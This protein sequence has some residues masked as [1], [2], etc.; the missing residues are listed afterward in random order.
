MKSIRSTRSLFAFLGAA[1]V[2]SAGS[3]A[4]ANYLFQPGPGYLAPNLPLNKDDYSAW[5]V[6]YTPYGSP[7]YPDIS[8]PFGTYQLASTAGVTPPANSSPVNP[9]A[10]WDPRNPTITQVGTSTAFII[11]PGTQGNIYSFSNPL[12]YQV[13]DATSYSD[14]L[15]L[16]QMQTEGTPVNFSSI[17]LQYTNSS[18]Q[19]VSLSPGQ[20]VTEYQ[21]ASVSGQGFSVTNRTALEWNL[22]GLNVSSFHIV[23]SSSAP[24]M[25]LQQVNMDTS[26]LYVSTVPQSRTWSANGNGVWS[27]GSNWAQGTSSIENANVLFN[28]SGAANVTL[29]ANHTVGLMTFGSAGNITLSSPGGFTL[30]ANTGIATTASATGTYTINNKYAFGDYN[31]FNIAS[32]KVQLNGVVSGNNGFFKQGEGTLELNGNNTFTG[33]VGMEGGT[34]RM[35][36]TNVY[37]GGTSIVWGKLVVAGNALNGT[38][39]AL[40]NDSSTISLGADSSLYSFQ[41]V[42]DPG[43]IVIDGDYTIGRNIAMAGG[44]FEKILGAQGT[45]QGAFFSGSIALG[46]STDVH[47]N[48]ANAGD[49]VTFNGGITGGA[50]ASSS[51]PSQI[52]VDGHGT[53]VLAGTNNSY[54]NDTLVKS[55][56]LRVATGG[57]LTSNGNLNVASGANL[58]VDGT[59]G[60]S[61]ALNLH[62]TLG[63][64]GTLNR[65]FTVD[66][67]STLTP[68]EGTGTL[69]TVSETWAGGGTLQ[70][71]LADA[72]GIKGAGWNFLQINGSLNITAS[73]ANAFHLDLASLGLDG[74]SGLALNFD[75]SKDYTWEIASTTGGIT[76]FN[77]SIFDLNE[78]T[79]ANTLSGT[80]SLNQEGNN[81]FLSYSYNPVAVPEPST[82]C[83]LFLGMG[84]LVFFR[85]RMAPSA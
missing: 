27:V 67:T 28:Q 70:F 55:G 57:S 81:L 61:G 62:G 5:D 22:T 9:G 79:F 72:T 23:F 16:F 30:T 42:T 14:G 3:Q 19:L 43:A 82:Y 6:L 50:A 4:K 15:V 52:T 58:M 65:V 41:D 2:L 60:G 21:S 7:N 48:A 69:T 76:G 12:S 45:S 54:A 34:L 78:S 46:T 84:V 13:A 33:S 71:N 83:L 8:A 39:G 53:V 40:G 49:K 17:Q 25:S 80:F 31:V 35:A 11:G 38:P 47:L 77:A 37:S 51:A 24:S 10:Y 56:T 68:G 64:T 29:D 32:G 26:P 66:S 73:A 44:T 63:G 1:V 75:P 36:G 20:Y 59:V 85:R 74:Q 18:G